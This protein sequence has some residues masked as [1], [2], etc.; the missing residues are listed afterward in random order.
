[1]FQVMFITQRSLGG[2]R[3]AGGGRNISLTALEDGVSRCCSEFIF[4]IIKLEEHQ[5]P[6][7]CTQFIHNK[8]ISH[9]HVHSPEQTSSVLQ[10]ALVPSKTTDIKEIPDVLPRS[11]S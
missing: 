1:M 5:P 2:Q 6:G 3:V 9:L 8:K 10:R 11:E 4:S 7:L